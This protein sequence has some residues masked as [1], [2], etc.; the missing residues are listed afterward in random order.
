MVDMPH[1]NAFVRKVLKGKQDKP[2]R[3]DNGNLPANFLDT[4]KAE[5]RGASFERNGNK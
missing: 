5:K 2:D 3:E 4:K 1:W